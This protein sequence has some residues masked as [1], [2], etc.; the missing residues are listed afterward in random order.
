MNKEEHDKAV[1]SLKEICREMGCSKVSSYTCDEAPQLCKIIRKL[2][3]PSNN[4]VS[5]GQWRK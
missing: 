1:A 2:V 4:K 5:C 3:M